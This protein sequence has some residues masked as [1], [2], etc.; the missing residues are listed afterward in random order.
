MGIHGQKSSE[1]WCSSSSLFLR[2]MMEISCRW[3]YS[4]GTF[5]KSYMLI[6]F[7]AAGVL[8]QDATSFQTSE[9]NMDLFLSFN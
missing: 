4:M 3:L 7:T 5:N 1:M 2:A 6:S 9:N 8:E